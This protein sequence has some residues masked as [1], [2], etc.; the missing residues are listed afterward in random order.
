MNLCHLIIP[1]L[2]QKTPQLH[3]NPFSSA[4]F[5]FYRGRE[6]QEKGKPDTPGTSEGTAGPHLRGADASLHDQ[7]EQGGDQHLLELL[8]ERDAVQGGGAADRGGA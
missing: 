4:I 1:P 7:R 2:G 5:F 8:C 6:A 3:T